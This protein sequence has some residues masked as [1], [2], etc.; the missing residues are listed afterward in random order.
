MPRRKAGNEAQTETIESTE[1][2]PMSEIT[3]LAKTPPKLIREKAERLTGQ[4]FDDY[5][6]ANKGKPCDK[7]AYGAGFYTTIT[8]TETNEVTVKVHKE[9][10]YNA[11]AEALMGVPFEAPKR[12]YTARKNRA[13]IVS[14][15]AIGNIVV[16]ARH[17]D[18]AGFASGDKLLVTATEGQ[19]VL[20]LHAKAPVEAAEEAPA[21][22]D[23]DVLEVD[24]ELDI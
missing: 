23:A 21:E 12:A 2:A 15:T 19:I 6:A 24:D 9:E 3:E 5:L 17:S 16:G 10:F 8:N 20:T 7:A 13:P 4:A 22:E 14:V 1:I 18:T 11:M